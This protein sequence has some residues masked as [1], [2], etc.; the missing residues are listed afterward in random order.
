MVVV[1]TTALADRTR[2]WVIPMR[3]EPRA[4]LTFYDQEPGELKFVGI[5]APR[6]YRA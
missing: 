4:G 1:V 6:S 5:R 2:V 3:L